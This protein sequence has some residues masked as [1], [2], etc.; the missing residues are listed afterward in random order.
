[1]N[2]VFVVDKYKPVTSSNAVCMINI[3][4]ELKK[5]NHNVKLIAIYEGSTDYGE[6]DCKYVQPVETK[7]KTLF[8][9]L[10]CFFVYSRYNK[11]L[12]KNYY[13]AIVEIDKEIGI[14]YL[15][16]AHNLYEAIK[17]GQ[18]VKKYNK[19]IKCIGYFLDALSEAEI[20]NKK[21]NLKEWIV[22]QTLKKETKQIIKD[23]DIILIPEYWKGEYSKKMCF[24]GKNVKF[25]GLPNLTEEKLP[26]NVSKDKIE[27]VYCGYL[28]RNIRGVECIKDFSR[29]LDINKN[30]EI[31][32]YSKGKEEELNEFCNKYPNN[33]FLHG[34][35]DRATLEKVLQDANYFLNISNRVT[36][37]VPGKL[38]EYLSYA[39]PII[40][41][42][43][44][45]NDPTMVYINK[46]D[47]S[48]NLVDGKDTDIN[49]FNRFIEENKFATLDYENVKETFK[50][51][52]PTY[53]IKLM[54]EEI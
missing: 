50:E 28:N 41:Y 25:V 39:K 48:Y 46:Y 19:K 17:A 9:Y 52:L 34:Y 37:Y 40:N 49:D 1:M 16:C 10:K 38:F 47:L 20:V 3:M 24:V 35:V 22:I 54:L 18:Q 5:N 13:D 45:D 42:Q 4:R 43:Y 21:F 30:I 53:S 26:S 31:H 11:G 12:V 36:N 23:L 7:D 44:I 2:F 8:E 6:F 33:V 27:I 29:L 32:F 15:V 14:D 51:C